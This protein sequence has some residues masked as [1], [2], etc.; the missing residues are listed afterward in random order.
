MQNINLQRIIQFIIQKYILNYIIW[1]VILHYK[2]Y[3]LECNLESNFYITNYTI[4]NMYELC[5]MTY[6]IWNYNYNRDII[7]TL[8]NTRKE[9]GVQKEIPSVN[10]LNQSNYFG[11]MKFKV[12]NNSNENDYCSLIKLNFFNIR[13]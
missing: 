5:N 4:Q 10:N 8:K 12:Y 1:N 7:R 9:Y 3:N 6:V 13:V 2:L 11:P